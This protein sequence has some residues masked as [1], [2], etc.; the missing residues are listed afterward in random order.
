MSASGVLPPNAVAPHAVARL[1]A[2][3]LAA[4]VKAFVARG[5]ASVRCDGCRLKASHCI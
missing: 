5:S 3:R 2:V 1:R 4:S